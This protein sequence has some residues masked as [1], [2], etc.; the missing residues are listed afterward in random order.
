MEKQSNH[1]LLFCRTFFGWGFFFC[2]G[3]KQRT[4]Y[5]PIFRET[6]KSLLEGGRMLDSFNQDYLAYLKK[7]LIKH[8][9]LAKPIK[10]K[11]QEVNHRT[12]L[13]FNI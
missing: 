1:P 8:K 9:K 5:Q 3:Y 11:I 7:Y 10:K 4:Q 12:R 6:D 13:C 2:I